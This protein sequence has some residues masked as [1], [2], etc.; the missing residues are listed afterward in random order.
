[1]IQHKMAA[2]FLIVSVMVITGCETV[3]RPHLSAEMSHVLSSRRV[4][5]G[6][7]DVSGLNRLPPGE[8]VPVQTNAAEI[9]H[10]PKT[11]GEDAFNFTVVLDHSNGVFWIVRDGGIRPDHIV[12][13]PGKI[14][15]PR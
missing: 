9:Y 10:L 15:E 5:N 13:G 7:M 3:E 14:N 12:F 6:D 1:M 2:L 8:E 4:S 11:S